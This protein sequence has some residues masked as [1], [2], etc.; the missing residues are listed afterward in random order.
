MD[1]A[2]LDALKGGATAW[3]LDVTR[4]RWA[5]AVRLPSGRP[6]VG[7]VETVREALEVIDAA[8]TIGI[9]IPIGLAATGARAADQQARLVL[10]GPARSRVFATPPRAIVED[11]RPA[12]NAQLQALSRSLWGRGVSA[13][14]LALRPRIREV[15]LLVRSDERARAALREV[16]PEVS[17]RLLTDTDAPSKHT[18]AGIR[19]RVRALTAVFG[20]SVE[21][22]AETP[23]AG[24]GTD[25]VLDALLALWSAERVAAGSARILGGA[26]DEHG[27]RMAIHA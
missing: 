6:H 2:L 1:P 13:Q 11:D 22:L 27:L 10:A 21:A 25:D 15:D 4:G 23:P 26:L 16:H 24:V 7:L 18:Y 14:A 19:F 8:P 9:D 12:G 17:L 20:P 3:G 5:I